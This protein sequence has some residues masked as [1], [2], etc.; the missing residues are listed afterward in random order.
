MTEIADAAAALDE[1]VRAD[2]AR[3]ELRGDP[4][5]P[6]I[7]RLRLVLDEASC[8]DCVLPRPVLEAIASDQLRRR[9]PTLVSVEIEDPREQP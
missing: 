9:F 3:F 5:P 4:G 2:G 1:L 7:L 6:G 8:G